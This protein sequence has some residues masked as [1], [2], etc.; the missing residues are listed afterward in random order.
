M[1][2]ALELPRATRRALDSL[3]DA[4]GRLTYF[5]Y[6]DEIPARDI[7]RLVAQHDLEASGLTAVSDDEGRTITRI[8]ENAWLTLMWNRLPFG[9]FEVVAF[10][11]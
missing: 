6:F 11:N 3:N 2:T 4:L 10:A 5:E 8:A 7:A 1:T 9:R